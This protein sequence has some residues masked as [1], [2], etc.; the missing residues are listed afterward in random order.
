[1]NYAGI[2]P[3]FFVVVGANW[4]AAPPQF[5]PTTTF[6]SGWCG[7]RVVGLPIGVFGKQRHVTPDP[8]I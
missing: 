1:M 5:A 4:L 2:L 7:W 3:A 6:F 8:D